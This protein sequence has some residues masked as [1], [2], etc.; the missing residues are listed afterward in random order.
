MIGA[1]TSTPLVPPTSPRDASDGGEEL[2]FAS[3]LAEFFAGDDAS[4]GAAS[5]AESPVTAQRELA[6]DAVDAHPALST[7]GAFAL[8]AAEAGSA[9]PSASAAPLDDTRSSAPAFPPMPPPPVG[10]TVARRLPTSPTATQTGETV[11]GTRHAPAHAATP[12][13][14]SALPTPIATSVT[15]VTTDAPAPQPSGLGG[16]APAAVATVFASAPSIDV[17]AAANAEA[18]APAP[19]AASLAPVVVIPPVAAT[20]SPVPAAAAT[21]T[22]NLSAAPSPVPITSL[23]AP[24]LAV[25]SAGLGEHVVTVSIAPAH[26]GPVSIRATVTAE[27]TRIELL[28]PTDAAR[29]AVR[30]VLADIRRELGDGAGS[31]RIDVSSPSSAS[32]AASSAASSDRGGDSRLHDGAARDGDNESTKP[33]ESGTSTS[34]SHAD[35][36]GGP[37]EP[38]PHDAATDLQRPGLSR[39]LDVTV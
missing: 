15:A 28:T 11:T 16:A 30:G 37:A 1:V 5:G 22:P 31:W 36:V 9:A 35:D 12:T 38:D 24:I 21:P 34:R 2:G 32:S 23:A 7:E 14:P 25:R 6:V 29:D 8:P 26:L 27:G 17:R 10:D 13:V 20:A 3:V 18:A 33:R 39:S 19:A 4:E